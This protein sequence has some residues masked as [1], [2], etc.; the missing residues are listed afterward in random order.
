MWREL[1]ADTKWYEVELTLDDLEPHSLF[2]RAQ[3]R[4]AAEGSFYMKEVVERMRPQVEECTDDDFFRKLRHVE[5]VD[6]A[7]SDQ[8]HGL[9]DWSGWYGAADD[10]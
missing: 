8:S 2:P 6:R 4:R 10:S 9:V 3:W 7:Q 1:P 5:P